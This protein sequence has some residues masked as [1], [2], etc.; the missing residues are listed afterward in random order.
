M[1]Q[2]VFF[3]PNTICI[4]LVPGTTNQLDQ[5]FLSMRVHSFKFYCPL[6]YVDTSTL[7]TDE[8]IPSGLAN[9]HVFTGYSNTQLLG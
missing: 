3:I 9:P 6:S 4:G 5:I 2:N 1:R 7:S 8:T